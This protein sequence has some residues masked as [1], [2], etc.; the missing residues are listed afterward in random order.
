MLSEQFVFE[1]H[2]PAR[3]LSFAPVTLL[4]EFQV[5]LSLCSQLPFGVCLTDVNSSH[6][7]QIECTGMIHIKE[8]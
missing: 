7:I 3:A 8:Q 4:R 5:E 6:S 1:L 2:S